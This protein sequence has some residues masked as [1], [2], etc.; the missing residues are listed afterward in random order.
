M[1]KTGI[2]GSGLELDDQM[3]ST[4]GII[5]W[6]NWSI[7][8]PDEYL[9]AT[10]AMEL[11]LPWTAEFQPIMFN[12]QEV[13]ATIGKMVV[14]SDT[15]RVLGIVK[16]RYNII[17][18][19]D[20]FNFLDGLIES[21]ELRIETAGSLRHG[22]RIFIVAE[23]PGDLKIAGDEYKQYIFLGNSY[24]GSTNLYCMTTA[25][26]VVCANTWAA[27]IASADSIIKVR[28]SFN[29]EEKMKVA[30]KVLLKSTEY[31]GAFAKMGEVLAATPF[32]SE[33]FDG[34][35]KHLWPDA[36]SKR[37]MTV[38]LNNRDAFRVVANAN[39]LDTLRGTA[40]G[41]LQAAIDYSDHSRT[42]KDMSGTMGEDGYAAQERQL[43]RSLE[44]NSLKLA[45]AA[46]IQDATG[47]PILV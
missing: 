24:D 1:G 5:P 25:V 32:T 23:L 6:H 21:H 20:S 44:D 43:L 10:H 41:V 40:W 7:V 16:N 9:T 31:F 34:L 27:A 2:N 4:K 11:A 46:F 8:V 29:Y 15:Q 36:D 39:D 26:R 30:R 33:Q 14:R 38:A 22:S 18:P 12:G 45:A 19:Q 35:M 17:Q 37:G 42:I 28:H 47:V 13:P 3:V